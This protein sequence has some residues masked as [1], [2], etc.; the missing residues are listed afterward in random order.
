MGNESVRVFESEFQKKHPSWEP[1]SPSFFLENTVS[2]AERLLGTLLRVKERD[3]DQFTCVR[4]VETEAYSADDPASHSYR[5]I[6][7]RCAPM[8]ET[9]GIAY[10]YFI[11]GMYEMLNFV[12][13]P[14]DRAGAVLIR[15]AELVEGELWLQRR[16]KSSLK[17][18]WLN[19]PG[20]LT[21]ALGVQM[22]DN[23]EGLFGPRFRLYRDGFYPHMV[24]R[25]SRIGIKKAV[26]RKWRFYIEG[27]PGVSR[28]PKPS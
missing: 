13:E 20:R 11:Y 8:F 7:P 2:V 16:R 18:E 19:G 24:A 15:G 28:M 17:K 26:D 1:L 21:Q 14:A 4:I 23:R 9:G 5:G 22:S 3:S 6:T 10:V 25:S 27:S 12:T